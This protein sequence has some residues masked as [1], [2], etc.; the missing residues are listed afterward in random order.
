M[1]ISA[2]LS[3]NLQ[4]NRDRAQTNRL[5]VLHLVF[6]LDT[7]GLE[8]GVVN[9][10]NRLD[11]ERFAAS[12]CTFSAGGALESRLT[13]ERVKLFNTAR[14]WR[15]DFA[16][17]LR[18]AKFLRAHPVDILH[19]HSWG[20]L[21]EGVL[22]ARLAGVPIVVHGEHGVL[23]DKFRHRIAQRWLWAG[24]DQLLAVSSPLADRMSTLVDFRARKS[25]L[26]PMASIPIDFIRLPI[27]K[28]TTRASLVYPKAA[29]W[30][31]PLRGSC[32]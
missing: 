18:L 7:G 6:S 20:T 10:C 9:L 11:S 27:E 21:V 12:I 25:L 8:N 3:S 16:L 23:Q 14:W 15:H 32:R 13:T 26:S 4:A 30:S 22:A 19:T 5:R 17:P 28:Q 2:D 31:E 29:C 24:V 1:T